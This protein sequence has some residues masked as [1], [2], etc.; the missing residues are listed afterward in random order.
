MGLRKD[1]V[2]N[3]RKKE[4]FIRIKGFILLLGSVGSLVVGIKV[5]WD[6]VKEIIS[7]MTS[8]IFQGIVA[9]IFFSLS[10]ILFVLWIKQR[11][12]IFKSKLEEKTKQSDDLFE[13]TKLPPEDQIIT[14]EPSAYLEVVKREVSDIPNLHFKLNVHNHTYYLFVP[15]K[16]ELKCYNNGKKVVEDEWD[17][18][19]DKEY[20]SAKGYISVGERLPK[21]QPSSIILKVPIEKSYADWYNWDLEGYAIYANG[22][23]E[24]G[25]KID[26]HHQ[27]SDKNRLKLEKLL[28]DHLGDN[29][30]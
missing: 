4:T 9:V 13:L 20:I 30:K 28:E 6:I 26:T 22:G 23:E 16:V 5:G 12:G 19:K 18:E 25:V 1:V 2:D 29:K 24:R 17:I 27:M 21:Y 7:K 14:I 8:I 11:E 10:I 15:K 3:D